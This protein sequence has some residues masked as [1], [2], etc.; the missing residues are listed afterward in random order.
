MPRLCVALREQDVET[1]IHT[2]V[3]TN[4]PSNPFIVAHMQDFANFP[5]LGAL[6]LSSN[7]ARGL[8]AEISTSEIVHTHGL[9][10][11]PNVNAG[12]IAAKTER[13]LVVTPRG[14][15]APEAL[16]FSTRKK[17]LFWQFLQGPAYAHAAVWHATST[18]EA[19]DIRNFGVRAPIAIIPNGVDVPTSSG[20]R[21]PREGKQHN[22]LYLGRL[23]PKKGLSDLVAAW[24]HFAAERPDWML[25]IVGPDEGGHRAELEKMALELGVPRVVFNGPVYGAE[26]ELV[27]RDADLFVLP[28]RNENFGI[29]VAE[30]LAAGIPAIVSRGAPWSGLESE[31]CGWWVERGIEPLVSAFREAM[32]LCDDE[33]RVMGE[34]GRKLVARDF[35]WNRIARD[36]RSVYEWVLGKAERPSTVYL[37]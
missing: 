33:R 17:Q 25:R 15:L 35:N 8:L 21:V 9:W 20:P 24:S 23:H 32:A 34:Q 22:V 31:R 36:M 4:T 28:T 6:R 37:D 26:K 1:R 16:A 2:V 13:P 5:L 12:Q 14:M 3:G 27:L 18:A 19:G 11:M 29:A 7:L 10:L 30:A